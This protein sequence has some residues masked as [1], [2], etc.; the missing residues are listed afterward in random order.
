MMAWE[1]GAISIGKFLSAASQSMHPNNFRKYRCTFFICRRVRYGKIRLPRT[2]PPTVSGG[3]R[4]RSQS[5]MRSHAR[6]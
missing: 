6:S 3:W 4:F 5:H 1:N 2:E